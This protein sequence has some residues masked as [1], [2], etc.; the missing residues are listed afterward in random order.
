ML[1]L[2]VVQFGLEFG[3]C[4]VLVE[5]SRPFIKAS[6]FRV[7][8]VNC[9]WICYVLM[10]CCP[11]S[12]NVGVRQI[13]HVAVPVAY[14]HPVTDQILIGLVSKCKF[15]LLLGFWLERYGGVVSLGC[16]L[17]GLI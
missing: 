15:R 7:D 6:L 2:V 14:V 8:L 12:C 11:W 9:H 13:C 10:L 4:S 1:L 3:V 5:V 16:V 17:F